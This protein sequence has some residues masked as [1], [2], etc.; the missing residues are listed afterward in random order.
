MPT[1]N[2]TAMP[3][4]IEAG[5]QITTRGLDHG[6]NR[7]NAYELQAIYRVIAWVAVEQDTAE[8]IV[9]TITAAR[10]GVNDVGALP[11]KKYDDVIR[12]LVDLRLDDTRN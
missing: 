7:L 5:R 11:R 6:T 12:F 2:D 3:A 8:T 10:F 1:Q 9:H 4:R